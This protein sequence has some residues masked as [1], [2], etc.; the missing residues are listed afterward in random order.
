MEE[1]S[2]HILDILQNSREAGATKVLLRIVED[3]EKDILQVQVSDNGAGM[4][5]E[6]VQEVFNP[7]VTTRKTRDVG[8][9]LALLQETA[10]QCNGY[11]RL[12]SAPGKGT[13]L[14]AVFQHSHVDR[15]PLG[16]MAGTICAFL[17]DFKPMDLQ[18]THVKGNKRFF[19]DTA[20]FQKVAGVISPDRPGVFKV[21]RETIQQG[22][23]NL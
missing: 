11:V 16:D 7:F 18:Y 3:Q 6:L 5:P 1:L 12:Q 9:G 2:L 13:S 21:L 4:T 19:F 15:P 8:L 10:E 22:L 14:E 20:K 17:A 23:D